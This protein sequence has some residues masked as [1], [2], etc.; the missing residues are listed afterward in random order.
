MIL[1]LYI[2]SF[3]IFYFNIEND[4]WKKDN[5][6][7]KATGDKFCPLMYGP[8]VP[9][10]SYLFLFLQYSDEF[11][12]GNIKIFFELLPPREELAVWNPTSTRLGL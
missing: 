5:L 1:S 7:H 3:S 4:I 2:F 11:I 12:S 8:K 9:W 10:K 6:F